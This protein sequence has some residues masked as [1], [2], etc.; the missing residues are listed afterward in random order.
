MSHCSPLGQR[1]DPVLLPL[2]V[3]PDDLAVFLRV[4]SPNIITMSPSE[5]VSGHVFVSL[6]SITCDQLLPPPLWLPSPAVFDLCPAPSAV[7]LL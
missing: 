5:F 2:S 1:G 4:D 3:L 6:D 7:S